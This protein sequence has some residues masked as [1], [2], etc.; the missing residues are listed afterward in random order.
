MTDAGD[1]HI[2]F[3]RTALILVAL[4][5]LL[6]GAGAV[7]AWHASTDDGSGTGGRL[8]EVAPVSSTSQPPPSATSSPSSPSSQ[9]S[10]S[11]RSSTDTACR[12]AVA[13]A[14]TSLAAAVRVEKALAKH[15]KVMDMLLNGEISGHDALTMGTPSLIQGARAS[16]QFDQAYRDYLQVVRS[17][18]LSSR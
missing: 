9:S 6:V 13:K 14:D 16:A 8:S 15:T 1:D 5:A 17:C 3:T 10:Q 7:F 11:S 18:D 12:A 2:L 4:V